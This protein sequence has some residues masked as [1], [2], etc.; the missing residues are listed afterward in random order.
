MAKIKIKNISSIQIG[1]Q[2][3]GKN[4]TNADKSAEIYQVIQIRDLVLEGKNDE[5]LLPGRQ[6]VPYLSF[7]DFDTVS[8]SGNFKKYTV[9]QGHVIVQFR[10]R[11]MVAVPI[12]EILENTLASFH[13]YI[14]KP[15][16]KV[17]LPEYLAWYLNHPVSQAYFERYQRGT[18]IPMLPKE[19][20][21]KIEIN[22]PPLEKQHLIVELERSRQNEAIILNKLMV[23]RKKMINNIGLLVAS[24]LNK[25]EKL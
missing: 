25:K 17:I 7:D 5:K 23:L 21:S 14:L 8:P 20:F 2:P 11:R 12:L 15:D 10:G 6:F 16:P 3:R 1:Y 24:Q 22:I 9:N 19:F 13:F 4:T 18:H